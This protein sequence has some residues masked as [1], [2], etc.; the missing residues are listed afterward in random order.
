MRP[1][2]AIHISFGDPLGQSALMRSSSSSIKG[3]G[4][5][6]LQ[7]LEQAVRSRKVTQHLLVIGSAFRA[8][9]ASTSASPTA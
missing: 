7:G 3:L 1:A 6:G 5:F 9:A 4:T 8:S 2:C